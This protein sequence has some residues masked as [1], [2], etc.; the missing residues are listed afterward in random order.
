TMGLGRAASSAYA[1]NEV[2]LSPQTPLIG[3]KSSAR[4]LAYPSAHSK[5][6]VGKPVSS[7]E[8]RSLPSGSN[9]PIHSFSKPLRTLPVVSTV[10]PAPA[11]E[12]EKERGE[13][14]VKL[15]TFSNEANAQMLSQ[16]VAALSLEGKTLPVVRSDFVNEGKS[17][18]RVRVGPFADR[19]RAER[20]VQLVHQHVHITGTIVTAKK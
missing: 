11:S 3:L 1:A 20:V 13:Y 2:E 14:W 9:T 15:G 12:D 6:A 8:W 17:F 7:G 19:N 5:Q 18:Y 10:T 16:T 4:L